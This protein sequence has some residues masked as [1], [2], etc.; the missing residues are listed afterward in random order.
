MTTRGG[1]NTWATA[2]LW[3]VVTALCAGATVLTLLIGLAYV[4]P[5]GRAERVTVT[6]CAVHRAGKSDYV[7]CEGT[8]PDGT[9]IVVQGADHAGRTVEAVRAPWGHWIVPR[10]GLLA[11]AAAV[12]APLLLFL[13]TAACGAAAFRT[14]RRARDRST[15]GLLR[16]VGLR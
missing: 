3:A 1:T 2:V 8:L 15:A 11:R 7:R 12:A 10:T 4:A 5:H 9:R 13:A 14:A 16:P 6:A